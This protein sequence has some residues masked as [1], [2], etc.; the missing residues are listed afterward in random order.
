MPGAARFALAS[1]AADW[2]TDLLAASS[3]AMLRRAVFDALAR[4]QR[5]RGSAIDVRVKGGVAMPLGSVRSL[6]RRHVAAC[7]T[8]GNARP[9]GPRTQTNFNLDLPGQLAV[10]AD[11]APLSS[12]GPARWGDTGMFL[13]RPAWWREWRAKLV[14]NQ[15]GHMIAAALEHEAPNPASGKCDA[16]LQAPGTFEPLNR[17]EGVADALM[18]SATGK[19]TMRDWSATAA[20]AVHGADAARL[21]APAETRALTDK[22]QVC[23]RQERCGAARGEYPGVDRRKAAKARWLAPRYN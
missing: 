8:P 4:M 14:R 22:P 7:A 16:P 9:P 11:S 17:L 6:A 23:F 19:A 13:A 20:R 10:L 15:L 21:F 3:D 5:A 18:C 2:Q 12:A 1:P